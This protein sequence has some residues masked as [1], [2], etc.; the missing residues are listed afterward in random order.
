MGKVTV[1]WCRDCEHWI[2]AGSIGGPCPSLE[3]ERTLVKRVGYICK[4]PQPD[5]F[6]CSKLHRLVRDLKNCDHN[7]G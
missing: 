3:C 2:G 4:E 1:A 6:E 7:I 5:Y